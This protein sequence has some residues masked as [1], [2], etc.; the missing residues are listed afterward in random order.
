MRVLKRNSFNGDGYSL[1]LDLLAIHDLKYNIAVNTVAFVW[2]A[3]NVDVIARVL[4]IFEAQLEIG[5]AQILAS[6]RNQTNSY[7][8]FIFAPKFVSPPVG[9][10]MKIKRNDD[11]IDISFGQF[12]RKPDSF[13]YVYQTESI[14]VFVF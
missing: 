2:K 13:Q 4:R 10:E 3:L 8:I 1:N 11:L 9:D 6:R 12:D 7:F 14:C 5:T